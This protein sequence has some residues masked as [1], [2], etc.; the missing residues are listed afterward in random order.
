VDRNRNEITA[1]EI[2]DGT[3]QTGSK[4]WQKV[5]EIAGKI[6]W[7]CTDGNFAYET[8]LPTYSLKKK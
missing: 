5:K 4:I 7:V 6:K 8:I 1:F 3:W 2:G